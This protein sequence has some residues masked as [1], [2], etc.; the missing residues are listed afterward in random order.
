MK[1]IKKIYTYITN[2]FLFCLQLI[3]TIFINLKSDM[4]SFY[5]EEEIKE[6]VGMHKS[7]IRMGDGETALMLGESIY[8]QRYD[9]VLSKRLK[10]I[11]ANYNKQAEFV[12]CV[13]KRYIQA[14]NTELYKKKILRSWFISKGYFKYKYPK[15]IKYGDA[16]MFYINGFLEESILPQ[17]SNKKIICVTNEED[18]KS[19]K[20]LFNSFFDTVVWLAIPDKNS[21]DVYDDTLNKIENLIKDKE[22]I[23]KDT[24]VLVSCGPMGKVLAYDLSKKGVQ[25][26][27]V[28]H[29]LKTMFKKDLSLQKVLV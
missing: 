12:L 25:T 24:L 18:I 8:F 9:P 27:D 2:D 7:I 19:K 3:P 21:F 22:L 13:A 29:G 20:D 16:H 5:S 10:E 17:V 1:Y 6:Q 4:V 15:S 23:V 28:G 26:I 11:V 14:K